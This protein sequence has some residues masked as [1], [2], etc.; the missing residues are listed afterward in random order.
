MNDTGPQDCGIDI[1]SMRIRRIRLV[2]CPE[3]NEAAAVTG[4]RRLTSCSR[5]PEREGCDQ[6]CLAQI[7]T[8]VDGCLLRSRVSEWYADKVC[9]ECKR[10]IGEIAWTEAP[11]ALRL[12][13]G[14]SHEWKD[15]RP[16]DL[17]NLFAISEPLCWYCNN[18]DELK[19]VRPD[20]VVRRA[21]PNERPSPPLR[22]N[23]IY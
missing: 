12:F 6:I 19:R 21:R 9:V 22:G 5:W 3:T 17:P 4:K 16:A 2:T 13:D 15:F 11:P 1:K 23:A 8:A 18:L 14:T 20:L 7:A 10:P